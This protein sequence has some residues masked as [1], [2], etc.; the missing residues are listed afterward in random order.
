M[1]VVISIPAFNEEQTLP[2]VLQEIKE[3]MDATEYEYRVLV[4][5]DGSSDETFAVAEAL[6]ARVVRKRHSGLLETF[7][8]EMKECLAM[9]A[10]VI[11]HTDADGQYPAQFIPLLLEGVEKGNDL[12]LGSRFSG[13]IEHMPFMKRLGNVAF[14]KVFT[15]ICQTPITDST[16]GFRAFTKEV[17]QAIEYN[18]T[19]TY[20]QEQL[21]KAANLHFTISEVPIYARSTRESRLMKG[22][23]EYAMKAWINILRI[24]RDYQ[25]LAFFGKLGIIFITAGLLLGLWVLYLVI[26]NGDVGG[27]PKV[28]LSAL[29][30]LTGVQVVLFGFLADMKK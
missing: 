12:V 26:A 15:Q 28:I 30:L 18:T 19:F 25:P 2:F 10:D 8:L 11:V 3:V 20:T 6:G 16:T 23:F 14:A 7:K 29:L 27:L 21:I 1:F 22:P 4:V 9:G 24:Y 13:E 17:A 5:D